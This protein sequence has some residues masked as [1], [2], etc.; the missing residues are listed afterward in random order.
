MD[1]RLRDWHP[2]QG[3]VDEIVRELRP[4]LRCFARRE[5][6]A[7]AVEL[8]RRCSAGSVG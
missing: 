8:S 5:G 4:L 3:E 6:V 1:E 2:T 7:L